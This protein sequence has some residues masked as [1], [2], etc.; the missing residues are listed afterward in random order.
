MTL[1][2]SQS[3]SPSDR[4]VPKN[5]SF[6]N[7]WYSS[8][9]TKPKRVFRVFLIKRVETYDGYRPVAVMSVKRLK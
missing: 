6:W 9:S 5:T 4:D 2:Y 3:T 7:Y 1:P 8:F